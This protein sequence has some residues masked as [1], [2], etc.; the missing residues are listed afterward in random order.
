VEKTFE[1]VYENGVL[2]PLENL[3]LSDMQ[4]VLVTISDSTATDASAYFEPGE[5]SAAR[6]D[7]ISL[8]VVRR[9]LSS[10]PGSLSDT[11]NSSRE[12]RS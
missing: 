3:D 8:E 10:I 4:H 5:W 12:E 2:R 11:V 1:A 9:A 6:H 7:D